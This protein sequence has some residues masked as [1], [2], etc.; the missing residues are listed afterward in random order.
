MKE[1]D[2][3]H[4]RMRELPFIEK[5]MIIERLSDMNETLCGFSKKGQTAE[6]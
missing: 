6:K 2:A 1:K 3:Y 4:K 5:L